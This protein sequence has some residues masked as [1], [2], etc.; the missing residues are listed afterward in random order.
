[1]AKALFFILRQSFSRLLKSAKSK[2]NGLLLMNFRLGCVRT[3]NRLLYH[4]VEKSSKNLHL[5]FSTGASTY[6]GPQGTVMQISLL[7][8]NKN[9]C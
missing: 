6:G 8:Q 1:M 9:T 2:E 3:H 7:L 4:V 5:F